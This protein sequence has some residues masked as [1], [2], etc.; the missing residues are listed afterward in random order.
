[1]TAAL[2]CAAGS[3]TRMGGV[4]KEY[5]VLPGAFDGKK[6]PLTVLGASA[7]AFAALPEIGVIVITIPPSS[8][9]KEAEAA[10]GELP[11]GGTPV[12]FV[13]GGPTRRASVH[14]ALEFLKDHEPSLVLIHDGA[15]PWVSGKLIR[16]VISAV[17]RYG[18][19]LPLLPL[20]ETPK[21]IDSSGFVVRHLR[22]A[23][24]AAAQTPQG[25]RFPDILR[26]HELA[27]KKE[28]E[29]FE[30]T[31]DAEV[32]GEFIGKVAGVPGERTN[33]K[34][35]FPEDLEGEP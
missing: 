9:Q 7:A 35:T 13:H 28:Q 24:I 34:I 1:M 27:A 15:R 29:G 8:S 22:R 17:T 11:D 16:S 30:Y 23:S 25:F 33:K 10:L 2:I 32:W 14:L 6:R 4:K 31:D 20:G 18:S 5:Q 19:A 12:F 3:S 21:E 26:A